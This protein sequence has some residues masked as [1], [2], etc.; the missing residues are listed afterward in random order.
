MV[1]RDRSK[2]PKSRMEAG[3]PHS[4]YLSQ[5]A[6]DIVVA[7]RAC[8]SGSKFLLPSRYDADRYISKAT[9]NRVTKTVA[10]RAKEA[11]LPLEPFTEIV[12]LPRFVNSSGIG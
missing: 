1:D 4:F 12:R 5:Q 2:I 9:L 11:R 8:A 3:E 6:L 7:L 10:E